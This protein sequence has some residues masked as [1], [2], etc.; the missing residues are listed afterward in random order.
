MS[1]GLDQLLQKAGAFSFL[2]RELELIQADGQHRSPP[3]I[4]VSFFRQMEVCLTSK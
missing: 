3:G 2:D 4:R 1:T